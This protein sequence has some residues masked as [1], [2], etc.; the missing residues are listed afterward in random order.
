M[1]IGTVVEEL[2]T[3][4]IGMVI[5]RKNNLEIGVSFGHYHLSLTQK[6]TLTNQSRAKYL[7]H[8][9]VEKVFT[10]QELLNHGN[11]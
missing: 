4:R 7:R 9:G 11:K 10:T 1:K 6:P 2:K 8:F 5:W 3:G